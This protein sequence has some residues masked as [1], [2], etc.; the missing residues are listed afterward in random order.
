MQNSELSSHYLIIN[1]DI[2]NIE[3]QIN[4]IERMIL[5]FRTKNDSELLVQ[6]CD[7]LLCLWRQELERMPH[8]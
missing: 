5:D 7:A 6:V 8:V 3:E 4:N 1:K 2:K